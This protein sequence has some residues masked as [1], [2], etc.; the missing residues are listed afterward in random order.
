MSKQPPGGF[1]PVL[2]LHQWPPPSLMTDLL[3]EGKD[4]WVAALL[5][6]PRLYVQT[7]R[8]TL[9]VP[10][11]GR[12]GSTTQRKEQRRHFLT[13][14][15]P[16]LKELGFPKKE[17]EEPVKASAE[18]QHTPSA[19]EVLNAL[20]R[21]VTEHDGTGPTSKELASFGGWQMFDVSNR[22]GT[23]V[24]QQNKV[25]RN[26]D[27]NTYL[28]RDSIFKP[29]GTEVK[30]APEPAPEPPPTPATQELHRSRK[31]AKWPP[32]EEFAR[33]V[34]EI[35]AT[36]G[37][38]V[39]AVLMERFK[40]PGSAIESHI[41]DTYKRLGRQ[42]PTKREMLDSILKSTVKESAQ[43]MQDAPE[44]TQPAM[45]PQADTPATPAEPLT[46]YLCETCEDTGF[47][48]SEALGGACPDCPEGVRA[49]EKSI[50]TAGMT[51]T[52]ATVQPVLLLIN[53]DA[54]RQ[55]SYPPERTPLSTGDHYPELVTVN[56]KVRVSVWECVG[57]GILDGQRTVYAMWL[58]QDAVP[59]TVGASSTST[60]WTSF[61]ASRSTATAP[62]TPTGL[63]SRCP[64]AS[65]PPPSASS[66]LPG[67]ASGGRGRPGLSEL[68]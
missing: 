58:I 60:R 12:G 48:G 28:P 66:S 11:F 45:E 61:S 63:K 7:W 50:G 16:R 1:L 51:E 32:D 68:T 3:R 29:V 5:E 59:G 54:T 6:V 13:K 40:Y 19:D 20:R 44:T 64:K 17:A 24:G 38:K 62:S 8:R 33:I 42:R 2:R 37:I 31:F 15:R 43:T 9:K 35:Y 56:G 41:H 18:M 36:P 21:Y 22:L 57:V 47:V 52:A 55:M 65:T 34:E 46:A 49:W 23:L 53:G 14:W 30:P 39:G 27:T 25:I 26:T 4:T 67:S 10:P